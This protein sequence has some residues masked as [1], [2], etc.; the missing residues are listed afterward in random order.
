MSA[1]SWAQALTLA[2][3]AFFVVGFVINT[4][5]VK[6]VGPEYHRWG[7]PDWFH[8]VSGGLELFV[9][10]LLPAMATRLFGVALGSAR[11][12]RCAPLPGSL[13]TSSSPYPYRSSSSR[14][15]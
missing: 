9:A 2:L 7:Y 14:P 3:A 8:F 1:V 6:K 10:L 4:F 12:G 15:Q 13:G 11:P 5:M